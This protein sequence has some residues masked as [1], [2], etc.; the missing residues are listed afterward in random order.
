MHK[1]LY[2]TKVTEHDLKVILEEEQIYKLKKMSKFSGYALNDF[3][4][5]I[6][7]N[8]GNIKV[9]DYVALYGLVIGIFF[10]MWCLVLSM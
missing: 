2:K 6:V 9:G 8:P 7:L 3:P 5:I 4:D 1:K 10:V